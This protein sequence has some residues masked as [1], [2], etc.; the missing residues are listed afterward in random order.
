MT[1]STAVVL[2]E[3]RGA[4]LWI[5]INRPE[6]RNAL[7]AEVLAGIGEGY[8]AAHADPDVRAIV[9]TGAGDRAF[10]AGADLQPGAGFAFDLSR[11]SLD[12]ADLI[13][14]AGRATLPVIARVRGACMAG[15]MGLLAMTDLAV[16]ATDARFGLPE[17]KVGVFPMQVMSLL[18]IMVPRRK[19]RE[20]ALV[21]EPFGTDE[22]LA[23]GLINHAV[24]PEQLDAKVQS[25]VDAL[26]RNSPTAIR[27]GKYALKAIESM[28]FDEALAHT[29]S[30][31][32]ALSMTEDA[33][34]G[35]AAFNEKRP[36][37]WTGR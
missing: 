19:A 3:R 15:G 36:P 20:W 7:N 18:Q 31:I 11:P 33:R 23:S 16:A 5:T 21:G 13:R 29:E 35:L 2:H 37:R 8:R 22:A 25:L 24:P 12:Y 27:R 17:V 32:I 10:C 1:D 9:L 34:E 14:E 6:R 30:Q 28:G 4:A 26:A